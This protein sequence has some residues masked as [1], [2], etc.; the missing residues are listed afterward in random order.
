MAKVT[1]KS[2]VKPKAR[3]PAKKKGLVARLDASLQKNN[4]LLFRLGAGFTLLILITVIVFGFRVRDINARAAAETPKG[5]QF[6]S[7]IAFTWD[8]SVKPV[9]EMYNPPNNYKLVSVSVI[10]LNQQQ[11][12]I[13]LAPSIE[14][15][16]RD[17]TGEH[18][19]MAFAALPNPF[20][21]GEYDSGKTASGDLS[22][23]IPKKSTGLE[24][25]YQLADT[26]G[27]GVPVC[28]AM[29]QYSLAN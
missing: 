21:A 12:T 20:I 10:I 14:S 4:H 3:K 6:I 27:G 9:V 28:V 23:A 13:W 2:A 16:V 5:N 11:R 26:N 24:W 1:K 18:Y 7:V 17:H 8:E 22:Y 25:C 19:N 15:Y 29:N